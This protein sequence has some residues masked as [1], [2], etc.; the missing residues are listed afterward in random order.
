[1]AAQPAGSSRRSAVAHLDGDGTAPDFERAVKLVTGQHIDLHGPA[2]PAGGWV[3]TGVP[4]GGAAWGYAA[5]GTVFFGVSRNEKAC[6]DWRNAV[7]VYENIDHEVFS[8][9]FGLMDVQRLR[10][11]EQLTNHRLDLVNATLDQ[12]KRMTDKV[13]NGNLAGSAVAMLAEK[14]RELGGY[15]SIQ[16]NLLAEPAPV[17]PK[18]L[19]DAAEALAECGRQLSYIWWESNQVLL[20]A[21]DYEIGAVRNNIDSYL[22]MTGLGGT[23]DI[24]AGTEQLQPPMD[25]IRQVLAGYDSTVAGGLPAGMDPIVGDVTTAPV[26]DAVNAAITKRITVELNKLDPVARLQLQKVRTAYNAAADRLAGLPV[27]PL[28]RS[29]VTLRPTQGRQTP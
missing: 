20:N 5:G 27:Q 4:L 13:T 18:V 7:W 21:P 28:Q 16:R 2:A 1:M 9:R 15:I 12:I 10:D 14:L 3:A 26:W 11:A 25:Q 29:T 17:V 22:S 19:H 6:T 24:P 8:G 23:G